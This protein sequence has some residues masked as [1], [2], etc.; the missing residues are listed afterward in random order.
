MHSRRQIKFNCAKYKCHSRP[1]IRP[2]L[3]EWLLYFRHGYA[4]SQGNS[5][6]NTRELQCR[7]PRILF[8]RQHATRLLIHQWPWRPSFVA[9][10]LSFTSE[11][12]FH[13]T[14]ALTA[15]YSIT[16]TRL[17]SL[18]AE[19]FTNTNTLLTSVTVLP[20]TLRPPYDSLYRAHLR[21]VLAVNASS[22]NKVRQ[23]TNLCHSFLYSIPPP[24]LQLST[25]FWDTS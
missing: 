13:I 9:F 15:F 20:W 6:L 3:G 14:Q 8:T 18:L 24:P 11:N 12:P 16:F 25:K 10:L 7:R 2:I 21:K 22:L 5:N 17:Y 1:Q 23:D 19:D 4:L